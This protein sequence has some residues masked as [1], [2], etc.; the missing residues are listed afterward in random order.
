MLSIHGAFNS[1]GPVSVLERQITLFF[2]GNILQYIGSFVVSLE[3]DPREQE[4]S[5]LC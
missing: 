5:V 4:E 3:C 2:C 1:K